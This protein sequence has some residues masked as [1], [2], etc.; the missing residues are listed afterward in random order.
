MTENE[1]DF[2]PPDMPLIPRPDVLDPDR[3]TMPERD[4]VID[5]LAD[6]VAVVDGDVTHARS[7]LSDVHEDD[8]DVALREFLDQP[9]VHFGGHHCDPVVNVGVHVRA[10]AIRRLAD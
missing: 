10:A 5:R 9:Q 7:H 4:D 3:L 8:R 1:H 6:A 2:L